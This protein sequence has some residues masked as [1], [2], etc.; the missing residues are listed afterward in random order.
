MT[1]RRS[2]FPSKPWSGDQGRAPP[3]CKKAAGSLQTDSFRA[4][5]QKGPRSRTPV[6]LDS[7]QGSPA[8]LGELPGCTGRGELGGARSLAQPPALSLLVFQAFGE[9]SVYRAQERNRRATFQGKRPLWL[10]CLPH[11]S[12]ALGRNGWKTQ[13]T[14]TPSARQMGPLTPELLQGP[15]LRTFDYRLAL[16]VYLYKD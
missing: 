10:V 16:A 11:T 2:S 9:A 13:H 12:C 8:L 7:V 5:L 15:D 1:C 4:S 14:P 6:R 3:V